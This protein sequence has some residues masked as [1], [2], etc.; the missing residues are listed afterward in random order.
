MLEVG[1]GRGAGGGAGGGRQRHAE[2]LASGKL[3]RLDAVGHELGPAGDRAEAEVV[4]ARG[5]E[6]AEQPGHVGLVAGALP[7]QHVGVEEDERRAHA[8]GL[9]EHLDGC[10]CDLA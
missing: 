2:R 1:Q 6:L 8:C 10:A 4:R 3:D 9:A 5:C 7:T